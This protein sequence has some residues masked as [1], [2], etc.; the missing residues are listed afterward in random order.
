MTR[1][2]AVIAV[3]PARG[4]TGGAERL[5]EGLVSALNKSG[6]RA[7]LINVVS[8]ESCFEAIE[9]TYLRIYDLDLSAYDGVISTKA[10]SYLIRHPNHICYLIHTMRVFYDMFENEFPHPTKELMKQRNFILNLDS[11][12]LSYPRTKKIFVIGNEVKNRLLKFNYLKSTVLYPALPSDNFRQGSYQYIFTISRLHRWKRLDLIIKAMK[13]IDRPLELKIAGTGEDE[14]WFRE[15]ADGDK[16][17]TF[18]GH[19]SDEELIGLYSNALVVP[20]VPKMEDYGYITIEAFRSCKPL[21][22]CTDSGEP[23]YI[24]RDG[25]SGFICPPEPEAIASK[26]EYLYDNPEI[27]KKMGLHGKDS[28][29]E[30]TWEHVS[31]K[32]LQ[33]LGLNS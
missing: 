20:F 24:V 15:L 1:R 5:Y 17:I 16:R 18:L 28:V 14:A 29:K 30:I 19:V 23:S 26:I 32:L 2:V 4:E 10:P 3:K 21:I 9:E 8:D 7:D 22:T 13:H 12:A 25:E 6:A 31:E 33:A 11:A 27:A